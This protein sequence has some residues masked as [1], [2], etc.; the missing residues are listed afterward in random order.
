[1]QKI[2]KGF[3]FL[4]IMNFTTNK[5]KK[6]IKNKDINN[7][8]ATLTQNCNSQEVASHKKKN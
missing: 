6:M 2:N 8:K 7:N 3:N 4:Y 1:M 5:M